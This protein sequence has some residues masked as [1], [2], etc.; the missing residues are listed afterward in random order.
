[1]IAGESAREHE[2]FSALLAR[3]FSVESLLV[4]CA[5]YTSGTLVR[6]DHFLAAG[7]FDREIDAYEDLDLYLR[8]ADRWQI[9]AVNSTPLAQHRRHGSNTASHALYEGAL[10]VSR[11]HLASG[12]ERTPGRRRALLLERRVDSLWGLGDLSE[13]RRAA[14]RAARDE[15]ALLRHAR[16]R[17]RLVASLL[18][19]AFVTSLRR[20]R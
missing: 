5:M 12:V 7:G 3:G 17:K 16:F 20:I 8:L 11:K 6:R 13:A 1:V 19:T 18:P 15:P 4:D 2:R 14:L 9:V 10:H